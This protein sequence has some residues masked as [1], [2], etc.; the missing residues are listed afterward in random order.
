MKCKKD[1]Y[2]K[3]GGTIEFPVL[4]DNNKIKSSTEISDILKN[5]PDLTTNYIFVKSD[6]KDEV[7]KYLDD[8]KENILGST[9]LSE[10]REEK[11]I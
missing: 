7:K 1:D 9:K 3:K 8:N 10:L 6:I 2:R 5:S 11:R 4:S